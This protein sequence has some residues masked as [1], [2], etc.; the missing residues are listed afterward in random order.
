MQDI[1]QDAVQRVENYLSNYDTGTPA[2]ILADI[3][4][5]CRANGIDFL[6]ELD[7][8]HGYVEEELS[9]MEETQ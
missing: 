4:H 2:D 5:Y 9:F 3:I 7:G 1:I 6:D 8:A